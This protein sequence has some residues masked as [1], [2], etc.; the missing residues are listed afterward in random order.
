VS[1]VKVLGAVAA[2]MIEERLREAAKTAKKPVIRVVNFAPDEVEIITS[3]LAGR[4]LPDREDPV[5]VIVAA[6][7]EPLDYLAGL[8]PPQERLSETATLTAYRNDL[9]EDGQVFIEIGSQPDSEG[10]GSLFRFAERDLSH[11]VTTRGPRKPVAT[12]PTFS[13]TMP[14]VS[15]AA[16][17]DQPNSPRIYPRSSNLF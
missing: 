2:S 9:S 17:L 16:A 15:T 7:S 3:F 11:S 14:G 10:L 13:L 8:E 12:A 1:T 4:K 5:R 6:R